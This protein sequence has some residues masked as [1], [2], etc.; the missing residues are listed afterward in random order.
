MFPFSLYRLADTI[1][2]FARD[3][4]SFAKLSRALYGSITDPQ[5]S[6]VCIILAIFPVD[7][8]SRA[9]LTECI[10][11]KPSKVLYPVEYWPKTSTEHDAVLESFIV[12]LER[13]LGVQRSRIS[14]EEV[15][16][17]T[18]PVPEN[19]TLEKYLE[20]V[21]EWAGNPSQWKDFLSPFITKYKSIYGRDPA[22]NPQL[23]F[24][25]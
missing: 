8:V 5:F 25:R 12:R 6:K 4:P 14:L 3:A 13:Y 11:Q 23:Q 7:Y 16:A 15:W 21:F 17:T 20:H 1:G 19:T 18:K 2:G 9:L 10:P 24:K 22:L